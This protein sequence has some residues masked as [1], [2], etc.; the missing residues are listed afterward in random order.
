MEP[1]FITARSSKKAHEFEIIIETFLRHTGEAPRGRLVWG[2]TLPGRMLDVA[3][4]GVHAELVDDTAN[5]ITQT[6]DPD[7]ACARFAFRGSR[8]EG[9]VRRLQASGRLLGGLRSVVA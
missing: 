6:G 9:F 7:Q 2:P 1:N 4:S 3:L 5:S 8:W